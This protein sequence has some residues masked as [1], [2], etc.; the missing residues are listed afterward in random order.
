MPNFPP[1]LVPV[2]DDNQ[3]DPF[4]AEVKLPFQADDKEFE[5]TND[6]VTAEWFAKNTETIA[7]LSGLAEVL[8]EEIANLHVHLRRKEYFL[9][10]VKN[11]LLAKNYTKITK[12]AD[13]SIQDAFVRYQ[14]TEEGKEAEYEMMEQEIEDIRRMIEVREPRR[15]QLYSRLKALRDS[16][17]S[18]RHYLDH[19]KLEKRLQALTQGMKL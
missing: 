5:F 18:A 7:H 3:I 9:T 17:E 19:A 14:V 11:R 15:D 16:Q 8:E 2:P 4:W 1:E 10:R 13:K 12:S 6:V